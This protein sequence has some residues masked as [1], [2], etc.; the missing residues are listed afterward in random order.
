[1]LVV[2]LALFVVPTP[3]VALA[4]VVGRFVSE[5]TRILLLVASTPIAWLATAIVCLTPRRLRVGMDGL[6]YTW[7]GSGRYIAH[8][9]V[10]GARPTVSTVR[11]RRGSSS[12]ASLELRLASGSTVKLPVARGGEHDVL[13]AAEGI[14]RSLRLVSNV[15]S[16]IDRDEPGFPIPPLTA[17]PEAWLAE[18]RARNAGGEGAYRSAGPERGALWRAIR[19]PRSTRARRAAAAAIIATALGPGDADGLRGVAKA[20][21]DPVLARVFEA[22]AAVEPRALAAALQ[23]VTP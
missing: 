6:A 16:E 11:T 2:L 18:V 22:A 19:D 13:S 21:A 7:F 14:L 9:D 5:D 4:G 20:T 8:G 15:G 23:K 3:F 17:N 10:T 1:V 12:V